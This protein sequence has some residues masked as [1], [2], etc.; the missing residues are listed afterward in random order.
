MSDQPHT[1]HPWTPQGETPIFQ[2]RWTAGRTFLAERRRHLTRKKTLT[3]L[4]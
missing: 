1:T 4:E 2:K 3:P